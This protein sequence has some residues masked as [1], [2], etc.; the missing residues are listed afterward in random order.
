MNPFDEEDAGDE[1]RSL[2][3]AVDVPPPGADVQRAITT[4]RR[5]RVRTAVTGGATALVVLA[6]V[7]TFV[8]FGPMRAGPSGSAAPA[9]PPAPRLAC[10]PAELPKPAGSADGTV[11][12]MDPSG[13]IVGGYVNERQPTPVVWR[14]GRPEVVPGVT[15]EVTGVTSDGTVIG[16]EL[17]DGHN[18]IGWIVRNGHA[19]NL[20]LPA[21]YQYASPI[22][23]NEHGA[24]V[25][26]VGTA[27]P[28]SSVPAIWSADGTV[29][30]LT[31]PAGVGDR[32][33]SS[34]AGDIGDDGTVVGDVHGQAIAWAPD[35]TP[36]VLPRL[37]NAAN[38]D[39]MG[40]AG[41]YVYGS[42]GHD[43][44]RWDLQSGRVVRIPTQVDSGARAGTASGDALINGFG[45]GRTLLQ[46]A[47]GHAVQL[48]GPSGGELTGAVAISAD[49]STVAGTFVVG[50]VNHPVVWHCG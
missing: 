39:A 50:D 44:V 43:A 41:H 12:S 37:P 45:V 26:G 8:A 10:A 6:A 21:G 40:I 28:N 9:A 20:A 33:L 19:S 1:L 35:G 2:M 23:V 38:G 14:D 25:G 11:T 36:T 34:A 4:G 48:L 3:L 18:T 22:A 17:V 29:H 16:F 30:L 27:E 13:R 5:A 32:D 42:S 49:G 24:V 47:D 15:G 46:P 7:G 31:V